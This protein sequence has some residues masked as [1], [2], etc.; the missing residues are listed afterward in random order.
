MR[1]FRL[2]A[3]AV[4][5]AVL[6]SAQVPAA[7]P[8]AAAPAEQP[9]DPLG[10]STPYGTVNGF[11]KAASADDY[12]RA[13]E[14]LNVRGNR[15][16]EIATQLK[17]VL[18]WGLTG[19]LGSVSRNPEGKVNDSL[20][21]QREKIGVIETPAGEV[22]IVL[23]RLEP[24]NSL[25]IWLFSAQTL[26]DVPV[27]YK[28]IEDRDVARVLP[29]ALRE[30]KFLDI[31]LWRWLGATCGLVLALV[32]SSLVSRLLMALMQPALRK[33][34]RDDLP[35]GNDALRWPIRLILIAAGL[36]IFSVYSVTLLAR[37]RWSDW[38]NA[39]AIVGFSWLL[40]RISDLLSEVKARNLIWQ[41]K[42][43]KITML[44]LSRRVFKIVVAIT[45]LVLLLRM[46]GVNVQ[47]MLAG[48]GIGGIALA[49]A[50]QKTLEN[51]FGGISLIMREAIRVGDSCMIGDRTAT[52]EDIGLGTTRVRTLDRTVISVPN[53][54]LSTQNLENLTMRDKGWFHQVFGLRYD[55]TPQQMRAVLAGI[56][57]VLRSDSRVEESTARVRFI[58]FGTSSFNIEI[59]AY[60]FRSDW[61]AILEVQ[62]D[63]LLQ[64]LEVIEEAGAKIAVPIVIDDRVS[65]GGL[66]ASPQQLPASKSGA[67]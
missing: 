38:A 45:A 65:S 9:E 22:E 49:L 2:T 66:A 64:V 21:A 42:A 25:P 34:F 6:V 35:K 28:E 12:A 46:G 20:P 33:Y 23:E 48:L 55:T 31:P 59:F 3:L 51:V 16:Q 32:S 18:D 41:Q 15:A 63:L 24:R 17:S 26:R 19:N 60:I 7:A 43:G 13:A 37:N 61:A 27:I 30:L 4:F 54:Q 36:K 56:D 11:L 57:K 53:A 44:N 67:S 52:V 1:L 8:S 29:A 39:I 50:A 40:T 10:R 47:S 5:S 62:E 14:Y 58:E